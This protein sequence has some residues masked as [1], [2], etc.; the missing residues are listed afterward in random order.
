MLLATLGVGY[1]GVPQRQSYLMF[2]VKGE[3]SRPAGKELESASQS[4]FANMGA[5]AKAGR[6]FAAG[7]L[8]DPT[9]VRRGIT[10][11]TAEDRGEV[12]TL[13]RD[14]Q[15]VRQG[16][17][18]VEAAP[19]DADLA[20]FN[21]NVNPDDIIEHRLVLW[22]RGMGMSPETP[23]MRSAHERLVRSV[24]KSHGP[25][26]WGLIGASEDPSFAK[27]SEAAIF[28]STDG[29][30][31]AKALSADPLVERRL[32]EVEVIRL[33]MSAGVVRPSGG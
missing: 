5:Q 11:V 15:F 13:F 7:P 12:P 33:W 6:L 23:E 16:V 21:P 22:R 26:V 20:R 4:H 32:L 18:K 24:G 31:I 8:Q 30:G 29:D 1:G 25:A 3:G 14:D 19:W 10:V 2:F 17:M 27:V 28:V 9:E